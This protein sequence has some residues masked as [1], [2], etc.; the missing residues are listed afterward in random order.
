MG[1]LSHRGY[2]AHR[3][4]AA[5]AWLGCTASLA[6]C[7]SRAPMPDAGAPPSSGALVVTP[8]MR[9]DI[10]AFTS[11]ALARYEVP[12]A[13]LAIIA[14]K[15]TVYQHGFG[16]RGL[17]DARP[18]TPDTLFM[19]GSITKSMTGLMTATLVDDGL[20]D[21][22]ARAVDVWPG[23]ALSDPVATPQIR[24]RNLLDH[25]SGVAGYD[26]ALVVQRASPGELVASLAGIPVLSAP[27]A[28]FHYSNQAFAAAGFA[29]ARAA[30]G[31]VAEADVAARYAAVM[32]ARVFEPAGMR[33]TTLDFDAAAASPDHALPHAFDPGA[34]RIAP[35]PLDLERFVGSVAPAGAVWSSAA[36]MARY[37]ITALTGVAPDGRRVVSANALQQTQTSYVT[38][39]DG[40]GYGLGWIVVDPAADHGRRALMHTGATNGFI[41]HIALL[42]DDQL[43]IVV[44]SNHVLADGF[45]QAV[46]AY[47]V[48][49]VL[50]LAHAGDDAL[51]ATLH[52]TE[53]SLVDL[54][55]S[56]QRAGQDDVAGLLGGYGARAE[57]AFDAAH[58]LTLITDFGALPLAMLPSAPG[59]FVTTGVTVGV[60]ATFA[61][62]TGGQRL[63]IRGVSDEPGTFPLTLARRP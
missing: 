42:P 51:V 26:A 62:D 39:Q 9:A 30:G 7:A 23:F 32:T 54:Q 25:T 8:A 24:V 13:A 33:A 12:G 45:T 17:D 31:E 1:S 52:T 19:I 37:A 49:T 36:D 57:V 4:R 22:D 29:A 60:A 56:T 58:G 27:G 6:G 21:W 48:E 11:A 40:Y 44:L 15:D 28:E 34:G 61:S 46:R 63:T 35:L 59:T 20:L 5:L 55:G 41:A 16:V 14:G 53:Q 3:A 43:G 38:V 2:Q 50:G 47:A 10:E 18:V